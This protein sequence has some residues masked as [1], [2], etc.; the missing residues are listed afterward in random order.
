MDTQCFPMKGKRVTNQS[1]PQTSG[2]F[3]EAY[4][5]IAVDVVSDTRSNLDM[6]LS[7][8]N[9]E[10]ATNICV[11]LNVETFDLFALLDFEGVFAR[12]QQ[13]EC[14]AFGML[15][16]LRWR[17]F[18]T[19]ITQKKGD[20]GF[21]LQASAHSEYWYHKLIER[22]ASHSPDAPKRKHWLQ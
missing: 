20:M 11:L 13:S 7:Y 5:D 21:S 19:A 1:L 3:I 8:T 9:R 17:V 15:A 4:D 18:T 16:F 10:I 22:Q 6:S 2:N 14:L 12:N